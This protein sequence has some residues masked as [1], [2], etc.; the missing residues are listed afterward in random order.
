MKKQ[1][2]ANYL[3][4]GILLFGVS[5]LLWN[6]EK[7]TETDLEHAHQ[8]VNN[9]SNKSFN[10]FLGN[11]KFTL[12][13]KE[14]ERSKYKGKSENKLYDFTIDSTSIREIKKKKTTTYTFFVKR[15]QKDAS[16]FENLVVKVDSLNKTEALLLKY[17]PI[18]AIKY[19]KEHNSLSFKGKITAIPLNVKKISFLAKERV[20]REVTTLYCTL[21]GPGASGTIYDRIH[22]ANS[23]CGDP[24]YYLSIT[25]EV[26]TDYGGGSFTWNS[27]GF[28]SY[29]DGSDN[30]NQGGAGGNYGDGSFDISP[31]N[32]P[33]GDSV[34]NCDVVARGL[35][36]RLGLDSSLLLG[37]SETNLE[38]IE[39]IATVK[40]DLSAIIDSPNFDPLNDTWLKLLREFAK[41]V[42]FSKNINN[43]LYEEFTF[44]L[45]L[46]LKNTLNRVARQLDGGGYP[47]N[48]IQREQEFMYD[49]KTGVAIL[50][51]EFANGLGKDERSFSTDFDITKQMIAGNVPNDIK[52]DFL[53]KLS[54][55][56]LTFN[57]F[58]QRTTPLSGGYS[59]SPDH[60]GVVDSF[61][62]HINA[63]WVQFFIGAA[64]AKYYPSTDPG[65]IIV[66]LTNGTS[67]KS[68]LLHVGNSYK[69]D[70]TG[71]NR[72]LST[73]YQTFRFKLK[74]Q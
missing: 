27:S 10:Q 32:Y 71:I 36:Y 58:L 7:I 2:I 37:L 31:I 14:L 33:C 54:D 16:Y 30:G 38:K 49:G 44:A 56:N 43:D 4:T 22:I 20:C 55:E 65:C 70:G 39:E 3:K 50:L 1:K 46:N 61:N 8:D 5:V 52:A 9:I 68:L 51:Y 59:F 40:E 34:H 53:K 74:I 48:E 63:N 26:C 23:D 57:Q 72:S 19:H 45:D 21:K 42:E 67:R 6:C 11:P 25:Q 24:M 62:K 60:T 13:I 28:G 15:K 18:E 29:S 69:R 73:I 66:E 17:E 35:A 12:A 64:S 41:L 47:T